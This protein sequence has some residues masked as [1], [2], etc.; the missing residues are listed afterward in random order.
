[1]TGKHDEALSEMERAR[2]LDPLS[3]IVSTD[4]ARLLCAAHETDRAIEL[5]NKVIGLDPNFAEAHRVLA[6]AYV[7]QSKNSAAI[8]QA[9]RGVDLDPNDYQRASLGYVYAVAGKPQEARKILAEMTRPAGN[10]QVSPVYLSF[11]HVGL[12]EKDRAFALL[13]QAYHDRSVLLTQVQ[14]E[15]IF[16]SLR[17]EPRLQDLWQRAEKRFNQE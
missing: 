6:L 13:E 4:E 9:R 14:F 5:L 16:D 1:M 2:Q 8:E 17:S 7:Q 3:L 10:R 15:I 11:I 12:A